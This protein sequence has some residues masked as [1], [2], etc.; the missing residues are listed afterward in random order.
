MCSCHLLLKRR[1]SGTGTHRGVECERSFNGKRMMV[2][3]LSLPWV[4]SS[5][6]SPPFL[7]NVSLL[8]LSLTLPL[9]DSKRSLVA[10]CNLTLPSASFGTALKAWLCLCL[11]FDT[12]GGLLQKR[13]VPSP[14]FI[15]HNDG[16]EFNHLPTIQNINQT[17]P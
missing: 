10:S 4:C 13:Y 8:L 1:P 16:T 2:R 15:C 11:Q 9:T 6:Q 7:F 12:V 5:S 14:A 3:R 17:R